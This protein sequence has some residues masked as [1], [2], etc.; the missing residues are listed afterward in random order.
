MKI[1]KYSSKDIESCMK[2][3]ESNCPKYFDK[4][5]HS[6]FEKWL[7]HQDDTNSSYCSPTYQN[8]LQD[9]YWVIINEVGSV[10]GCAGY[11]ISNNPSEARLAWGM[12]HSEHQGKG[13][14]KAIYQFRLEEIKANLPNFNITL[15]TSQH[16]FPFYAK[17]GMKV[18]QHIPQGY[19]SELDRFDMEL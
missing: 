19:G 13:Y 11:Y 10:V 1:R 12:I 8:T 9:N 2:I 18:I 15:G 14:G 16:T 7:L 3:F 6:L 5:E 4:S 17:M